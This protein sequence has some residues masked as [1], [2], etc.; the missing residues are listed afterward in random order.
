LI[1]IPID[2]RALAGNAAQAQ[3]LSRCASSTI[4]HRHFTSLSCSNSRTRRSDIFGN[5]ARVE[6]L[7]D[8]G[9][10]VGLDNRDQIR[11]ISQF[12][13]SVRNSPQARDDQ[14][15]AIVSLCFNWERK[16]AVCT[17]LLSLIWSPRTAF[18]CLYSDCNRKFG[19]RSDV[20][21]LHC[22]C[23]K[24]A[25]RPPKEDLIPVRG[26]DRKLSLKFVK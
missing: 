8:V 23:R 7:G 18:W 15:W 4:T 6:A 9:V 24:P 22:P 26:V 3:F 2:S 25:N 19:P 21:E 14:K 10:L 11:P 20:D 13:L 17:V 16:S 5:T 1:S 12:L